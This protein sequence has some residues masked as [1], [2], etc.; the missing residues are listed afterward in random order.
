MNEMFSESYENRIERLTQPQ[1]WDYS[2]FQD[3]MVAL[4]HGKR[5][6]VRIPARNRPESIHLQNLR[7]YIDSLVSSSEREKV[8]YGRIV[9][10]DT[11][12][13]KL[14][15][16]KTTSGTENELAL[17]NRKQPERERFQEIVG[18]IHTHPSSAFLL[19]HGFSGTDY[20]TFLIHPGQQFMMFTFGE[21]NRML[22]LK[23]SITPHVS[24][25]DLES[26][27]QSLS[28]EFL[29]RGQS[30]VADVIAFNKTTCAE[31]GI[32]LYQADKES[33]DLFV[34]VDVAS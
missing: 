32:V 4:A 11:G 29:K 20:K 9:L 33:N 25:D 26:R 31:F 27:I 34:R 1:C 23:T 24:P 14:V 6:S 18:S 21:S 7:T 19:H 10:A 3:V 8:E 15:M 22:A 30:S 12:L 13:N 17:F 16:G 28:D 5:G 2:R